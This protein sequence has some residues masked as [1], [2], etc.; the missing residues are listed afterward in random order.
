MIRNVLLASLL[1]VVVSVQLG[2]SQISEQDTILTVSY[3]LQ[4]GKK[5]FYTA[6]SKFEYSKGV[7]ESQEILEIWVMRKNDDGSWQLVLRNTETAAKTEERGAQVESTTDTSWAICDFFP[8]GRFARNRTMDRISQLDLYLP[9]IFI[10]LPREF[11]SATIEWESGDRPYGER[12]RYSASK[13]DTTQRSWIIQLTHETPLDVIYLIEQRAEVYI[14]LVKMIPVYKK[15]ENERSYGQYAG[16]GTYTVLLD[17]IIDLDTLTA[18]RHVDELMLFFAADSQ[19]NDIISRVE[20]NPQLLLQLRKEAEVLLNS[21]KRRITT[22]D[23]RMLITEI[24]NDLPEDFEYLTAQIRKR[25]KFVNKRSPR[26]E[27]RDFS[28]KK[29]SLDDYRGRVLLLDFWYRACPWCI[30]AMPTIKRLAQYFRDKDFSI[31][32]INTDKDRS[33]AIFVLEKMNLPYVNLEGRNLIKHY[34]VTS[35]PTFIIIDKQGLVRRIIIGYE[36]SL[37]DKL[38]RII[39]PLL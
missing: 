18:R 35:Y 12:T 9:N 11:R 19:Y 17:S 15:G 22:A 8:D 36:P 37:T 39:E 20:D 5:L 27:A 10:P 14:D 16:R 38:I 7:F 26:W 3:V 1:I 23:I 4:P 24:I 21:V 13:P 25:A 33:D 31:L 29:H 28:G 2:R 30:R 6:R 32:G 34:D